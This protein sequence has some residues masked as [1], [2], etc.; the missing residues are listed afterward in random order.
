[1][2]LYEIKEVYYNLLEME[3][4]DVSEYLKVV[5]GELEDKLQNIGLLYKSITAEAEA[6]KGEEKKLADRRKA[7][8]NK[9]S[10]LK[11][12]LYVEMQQLNIDKINKPNI[13]LSIAK[14][15]PKLVIHDETHIP[16]KYT[17]EVVTISIDNARLKEDVKNGLVVEG[18]E[19][20]QETSLRIK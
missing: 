20:I 5:E 11:D 15:P 18:V 2:R 6:I 14:N 10:S 16:M 8:E 7:I 19:V 17:N 9:A 12:W 3:D 13:V 1:M 4:V